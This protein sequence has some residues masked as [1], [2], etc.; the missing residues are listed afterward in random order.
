MKAFRVIFAL[1]LAIGMSAQA[2]DFPSKPV[3]LVVPF[4]PGAPESVVR[5]I[6]ERLAKRWAQPVV[7]ENKPGAAGNLAAASAARA[8]A[9]GY[10]LLVVT[11]V[12]M[13]VNPLL[14]RTMS[15]DPVKDF[16]PVSTL[17]DFPSAMFVGPQ[18]GITSLADLVARAKRQPDRVIYGSW[19]VGSASHLGVEQFSALSG[20]KL[21]HVPYKGLS[22]VELALKAGDIAVGFAGIGSAV[23]GRQNGVSV[24]IAVAGD[25]R[26]PS[27][28]D[29]PTF[30]EAGY[31]KMQG[32]NWWGIV[33]PAKTP[34]A[35]VDK[36][37]EDVQA[38]MNDPGF[39][40]ALLKTHNYSTVGDTP[41]QFAERIRATSNLWRPIVANLNIEKQ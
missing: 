34:K 9:D 19:G 2:A 17:V 35:V 30:A 33:A 24:P 15:F 3:H 12:M 20:I 8:P 38:V 36:I 39:R 37:S 32:P 7:V 27:L 13:T 41:E 21:L 10:T 23:R 6:A 11:D 22:G 26:H 14:Y 4:T 5:E 18:S 31:P 40:A 25:S 28:P 29:V 16:A 1:L